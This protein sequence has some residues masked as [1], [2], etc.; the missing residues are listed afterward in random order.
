[1]YLMRIGPAGSERPV[2]R[3]DDTRYIDVTDVVGD[4]DKRSSATTDCFV[5]ARS[6]RSEVRPDSYRSSLESVS[7]PRW[8]DRTRFSASG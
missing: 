8:P 7:E 6:C 2:V 3:V 1:M 5:S 4:F